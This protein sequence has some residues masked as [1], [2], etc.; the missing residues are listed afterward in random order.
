MKS[1]SLFACLFL[2]LSSFA[3]T[4]LGK[5]TTIDDETGKKK[6][7]VELYKVDGKLFGKIV[8][9]YPREGREDNPK[10]KKCTDDRKDKP[11]VGMN[12][13]R[14]LT[15]NGSEWAEGSILDPEKGKIYAVKIWID[16]EDNNYL[17][18]RGYIGIFFRT[19]R[20]IRVVE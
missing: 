1:L 14:G 20:W 8:S 11:I 15:W 7:I 19:Q 18:V 3:Q 9:L 10:C 6:S 13:V 16:A 12:I 2:T 5:W 17:N 4:C